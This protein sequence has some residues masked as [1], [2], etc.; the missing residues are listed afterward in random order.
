MLKKRSRL[1]LKDVTSFQTYQFCFGKIELINI[2]EKSQVIPF[3]LHTLDSRQV[4]TQEHT[5][6]KATILRQKK[7][8]SKVI[9]NNCVTR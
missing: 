6:L 2:I 7:E 8:R 4:Q 1:N 5:K 9:L 3:L